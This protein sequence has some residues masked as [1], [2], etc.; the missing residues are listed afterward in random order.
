MCVFSLRPRARPRAR[1]PA[2]VCVCVWQAVL[3]GALGSLNF[4]SESVLIV[5]RD[6]CVCCTY[7]REYV[8]LAH[9]GT[10]VLLCACAASC[11]GA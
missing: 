3:H 9:S 8:P 1:G 7:V 10:D 6:R 2:R 5:A 4:N 11:I